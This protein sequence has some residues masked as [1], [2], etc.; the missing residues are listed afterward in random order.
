[1]GLGHDQ[2]PAVGADP[3]D[4]A[5][6]VALLIL[7]IL[8]NAALVGEGERAEEYL[9]DCVIAGRSARRNVARR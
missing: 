4:I 1:M 9:A 7:A 2:P 8:K 6:D 3:L 5:G